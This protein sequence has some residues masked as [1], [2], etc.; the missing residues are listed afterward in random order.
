MRRRK[1]DI[2]VAGRM[3]YIRHASEW[4]LDTL[5]RESAERRRQ[6][7]GIDPGRIVVAAEEDEIIGFGIAGMPLSDGAVCVTVF[8]RRD[9][10]NVGMSIVRHVLENEPEIKSLR[11][12]FDLPEHA[13]KMVVADRR[14]GAGRMSSCAVPEGGE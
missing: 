9:R 12:K 7:E 3:V 4:D 1:K 10:R 6:L 8:E 5:R 2:S 11:E 14:R 13:V